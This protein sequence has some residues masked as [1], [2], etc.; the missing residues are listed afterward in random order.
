ML[1]Q[2]ERCRLLFEAGTLMHVKITASFPIHNKYILLNVSPK[3]KMKHRKI[4][5]T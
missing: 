1:M 3:I 2:T 5:I 4:K